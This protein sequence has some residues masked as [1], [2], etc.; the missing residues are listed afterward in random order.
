MSA[1][2]RDMLRGKS[3]VYSVGPGDTVFDA[4]LA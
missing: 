1:T 4:F 3:D 2:V